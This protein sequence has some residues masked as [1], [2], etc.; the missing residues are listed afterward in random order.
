MKKRFR[1]YIDESGD[2]TYHQI[3]TPAKSVTLG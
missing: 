3:D 2:H 1:P